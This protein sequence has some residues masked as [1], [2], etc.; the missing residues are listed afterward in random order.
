MARQDGAGREIVAAVI[1][2]YNR[3]ELLCQNIAML[4]RQTRVPDRIYVVDNHGTDEAE[5]FARAQGLMADGRVRYHYLA[6]NLGGAGGFSYGARVAHEEGADYLWLMDDDGRA[7]DERALEL[8]LARAEALKIAN[9]KLM[10][11]SLVLCDGE[12]LS[13][14]LHGRKRVAEAMD[15]ARDGLIHRY[16]NPFNGTLVSAELAE[17]IGYPNGE[18][19]IKGDENDYLRRALRAGGFV[20]T[21]TQ[22]RYYHP[23]MTG[24]FMSF[25]GLRVEATN[26]APWKEYY[27]T[28]NAIYILLKDRDIPHL[29]AFLARRFIFFAFYRDI[30]PGVRRMM[31]LGARDGF[32]G[33]LGKKYAP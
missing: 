9:P 1:V 7:M 8:I 16:I 22:S 12:R 13:F 14:E 3:R 33:R 24:E 4:L 27:R 10:L 2:T 15:M 11:N 23:Q 20:A 29:A 26:E 21:V 28:R 31:L 30:R 19:F 5:A 18:F 17:A 6:E 25:L 32:L